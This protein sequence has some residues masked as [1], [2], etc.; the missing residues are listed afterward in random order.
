MTSSNLEDMPEPV[1]AGAPWALI[2]VMGVT[3]SGKSTFIRRVS[4][5]DTI[6]VGDGLKSCWCRSDSV[7]T[8]STDGTLGTSELKGYS[9]YYAGYNINLVDRYKLTAIDHHPHHS[10]TLSVRVS[11][12]P[13]ELKLMFCKTSRNG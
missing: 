7:S 13:S 10:L 4:G 8:P 5:D 6:V 1:K 2:A 12:I 3:G 11:T 9:F